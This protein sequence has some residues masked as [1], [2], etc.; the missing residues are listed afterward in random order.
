METMET[1]KIKPFL[2][3]ENQK[4]TFDISYISKSHFDMHDIVV[5]HYQQIVDFK[6]KTIR[7]ALIKLGWTPPPTTPNN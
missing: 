1:T 3:T 4:L 6:D 7:E 5:N 2:D